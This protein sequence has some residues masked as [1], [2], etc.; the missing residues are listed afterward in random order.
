MLLIHIILG[1][2]LQ[3][4]NQVR[5][6]EKIWFQ[7]YLNYKFNAPINHKNSAVFSPTDSA[8][9]LAHPTNRQKQ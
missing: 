3:L 7:K 6:I 1:Y 5:I 4:T 8:I 2:S 9:H